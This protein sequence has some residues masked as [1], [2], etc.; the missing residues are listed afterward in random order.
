MATE[1][2]IQDKRYWDIQHLQMPE[3]HDYKDDA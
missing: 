3:A 1:Q 2:D